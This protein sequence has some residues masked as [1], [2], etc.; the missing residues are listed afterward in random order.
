MSEV[1]NTQA[2]FPLRKVCEGLSAETDSKETQVVK[3][4]E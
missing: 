1:G 4:T 3:E 2:P